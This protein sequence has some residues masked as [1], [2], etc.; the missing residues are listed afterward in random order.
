MNKDGYQSTKTKAKAQALK[1]L[2]TEL[3][4]YRPDANDDNTKRIKAP[5]K[6]PKYKRWLSY[7]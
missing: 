6:K 5:Y 2:R 4:T 7:A 3:S 1:R